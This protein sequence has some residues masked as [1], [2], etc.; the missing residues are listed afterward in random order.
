MKLKYLNI[1]LFFEQSQFLLPVV[2]FF[3]FENGL[4]IQDYLLFQSITYVLYMILGVPVG[5]LSDHIS[6]KYALII[7]YILNM[8]RLFLY[9]CWN[10]YAVILI[11]EILMIFIRFFTT[12]LADSY[13]FEYLKEK[14]REEEM[15]T[16][17]G[18]ALMFM[19]FGVAVGSLL[20]PVI[21]REWGFEILLYTEFIF[22]TMGTILL[23]RVPKT[24]IYNRQQYTL[25]DIKKAFI[26]LWRNK[27]VRELVICN[28]LLYAAV[29]VFV[30]TFQPLMKL[31][32]VPT[33]LFG[34]VYFSNHAIRGISSRLTKKFMSWLGLEKLITI[35]FGSVDLGFLLMLL[36][37]ELRN[38]YLTLGIL[39]YICLVIGLQLMNQISYVNSSGHLPGYSSYKYFNM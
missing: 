32:L 30:S 19:S 4:T 21:Y 28:M 33:V 34:V 22:S 29:T 2:L 35:G 18:R 24:K 11:G 23:L 20:G 15:L 7:G 3:Y 13:I 17:S 5:Y 9:L 36:A 37:F 8:G 38:P 39:F 1:S 12:G 31:S 25:S 14:K 26:S 16:L 6:K 27:M 10:G